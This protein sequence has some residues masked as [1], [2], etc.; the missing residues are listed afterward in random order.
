M[1]RLEGQTAVITGA[2]GGIGSAAVHTFVKEGA[3]VLAV[4]IDEVKLDQLV[5]DLGDDRVS[6]YV[7]DVTQ[8]SEN[9]AMAD[10]A[11]ERYGGINH[12]LANAG[13]EGQ[14]RPILSYD[15]NTFDRVLAVN[16][17]GVW[18]GLRAVVP[19]MIESSGGS[20]V[21]TS[22]VAGLRGGPNVAPYS[23]SKHAVIGLMRSAAKEFAPHNIRVNTINPSPVETRMMRS[24]EAGSS[25]DDPDLAKRRIAANIPL[26]RYAEPSEIASVMLFLC[27]SDASW[28]TGSVYTVDGGNT[29]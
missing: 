7:V 25:P 3:N 18:L 5:D 16:V 28:I 22:S 13:I 8:A 12:F 1:G 10:V 17:K 29:A 19:K 21:I 20:V 11:V 23:T 14:V 24:L 2:A 6:S 26:G 15:E 9:Q 27:T 4:D